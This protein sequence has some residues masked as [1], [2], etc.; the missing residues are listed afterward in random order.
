MELPAN[1]SNSREQIAPKK[2]VEFITHNVWKNQQTGEI[3]VHFELMTT[4][5]K[6]HIIEVHKQTQSNV[7]L[8]NKIRESIVSRTV[9]FQNKEW[10]EPTNGTQIQQCI[11]TEEAE[12]IAL[13]Y[14]KDQT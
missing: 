10:I 14:M 13:S 6:N 11:N 5:G 1:W 12:A 8:I 7:N 9:E 3:L 4:S 2:S